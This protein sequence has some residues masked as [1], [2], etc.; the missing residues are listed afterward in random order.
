MENNKTFQIIQ[1]IRDLISLGKPVV[2]LETAVVSHGLPY[3]QNL[4]IAESME[5]NIRNSGVEPATIALIDGQIRIGLNLNDLRRL[6]TGDSLIKI[7]YRDLSLAVSKGWSGGTTVSATIF[8]ANNTGIKVFATGGIGGVHRH[9]SFDI[10]SDLFMLSKTPMI[11]VCSGVKSILDIPAT[12][13]YLETISV[14][15]LGYQTDEF[16]AFLSRNSGLKTQVSVNNIEEIVEIARAHWQIG[17]NSALIVAVPP[18][19]NTAL[20]TTELE[21]VTEKG[22]LLASQE[23]VSG[24][25]ITP[26]LLKYLQIKT[27][28]ASLKTNI[29]LL[30][31]N[32]KIAGL[33]AGKLFN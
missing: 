1:N 30:N 19:E 28:G 31:N 6:S 4:E 2:A 7:G 23:G 24:K 3:P 16:P 26:Y 12:V 14:P 21:Q 22:L 13:E 9:Y 25:D 5:Q 32:A 8:I 33:I 17:M 27:A 29:A 11:V 20:S 18:P 10:S 15:V